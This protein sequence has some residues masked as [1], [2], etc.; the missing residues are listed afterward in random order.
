[1]CMLMKYIRINLLYLFFSKVEI[2]AGLALKKLID[3]AYQIWQVAVHNSKD[4]ILGV[5][6]LDQRGNPLNYYGC[7]SSDHTFQPATVRQKRCDKC[8][9]LVAY[10]WNQ[11]KRYQKGCKFRFTYS[12]PVIKQKL[13]QTKKI[14]SLLQKELDDLKRCHSIE[15]QQPQE[16]LKQ[17]EELNGRDTL[18][19]VRLLKTVL[20]TNK[21]FNQDCF[22]Y[23]LIEQQLLCLQN[24]KGRSF[25]WDPAIV[26][27]TM[28]LQYYGGQQVIDLL[29][30]KTFQGQHSHGK[31]TVHPQHCN[32][33]L[34]ATSTLR[35]YL[36][37]FDPY[38]GLSNEKCTIIG[39]FLQQQ[40][41][42]LYGGLSFDEMEIQHGI[43]YLKSTGRLI[44]LV[45]GMVAEKDVDSL[46]EDVSTMLAKKVCDKLSH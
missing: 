16:A 29:R 24:T 30:G 13:Y 15:P 5:L 4:I 7:C 19:L 33:F 1:M 3:F 14:S 9:K 36:P 41:I 34:P 6:Q 44:G 28:S 37:I 27:W 46:P 12:S 11:Y 22:L 35:Q 42:P 10:I 2:C 32:L 26:H 17:E 25:Q 39:S 18:T 31:L 45:H 23:Q 40:C 38:V 20:L 43:T 8:Q 21:D